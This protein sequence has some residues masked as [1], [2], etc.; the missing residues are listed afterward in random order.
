MTRPTD[1]P[2]AYPATVTVRAYEGTPFRHEMLANMVA[3]TA[4]ALA[5]KHGAESLDVSVTPDSVTIALPQADSSL[6]PE[7][8]QDFRRMTTSWYRH[9]FGVSILWAEADG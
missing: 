2:P 9:R 1:S 6:L 3:A 5:E 7:L 4:R 8:L